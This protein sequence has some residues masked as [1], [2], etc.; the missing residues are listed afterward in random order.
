MEGITAELLGSAGMA[1]LSGMVPIGG[2]WLLVEAFGNSPT[3]ARDHALRLAAASE[4]HDA[5]TIDDPATRTL[6]W[7]VRE[8]VPAGRHG[9]R[10]ERQRGP[11]LKT[12][13][14][15]RTDWPTT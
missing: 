6:L 8:G 10:M 4:T 14:C 13:P 5:R 2:A 12:P 3:E 9:C 15:H 1:K 11:V 7:R